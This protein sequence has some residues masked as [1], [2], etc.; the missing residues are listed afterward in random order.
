MISENPVIVSFPDCVGCR[1]HNMDYPG[2]VDWGR[3]GKAVVEE[4][5][6]VELL[7]K[8]GRLS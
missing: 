6:I 3:V 7:G 1:F 5:L 8:E 4:K 2:T